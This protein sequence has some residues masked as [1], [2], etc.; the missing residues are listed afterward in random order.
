MMEL[1]DYQLKSPITLR[2]LW[3][4]G[5]RKVILVCPTGGGKTIIAAELIKKLKTAKKK[6]LFLVHRAELLNQSYKK[7]EAIGASITV[8]KSGDNRIKNEWDVMIATIQTLKNRIIPLVDCVI[9]DECH[10]SAAP[11]WQSLLNN[12]GCV[13]VGLTA[14]PVRLDGKSLADI[15][16]AQFVAITM[17][18]LLEKNYLCPLKWY[19]PIIPS[20]HIYPDVYDAWCK[21]AKNKKTI[22]FAKNV[23]HSLLIEKKFQGLV[24]HIDASTSPS[25]RAKIIE[26]FNQDKLLGLT[27]VNI[28]SEGLD[29]PQC[30]CIILA[31][32]TT[33]LTSFLQKIGRGMRPH[34]S[35]TECLILDLGGNLLVHGYPE[36]IKFEK[37][38]VPTNAKPYKNTQIKVIICSVCFIAIKSYP[39]ANCGN[40]PVERNGSITEQSVILEEAAL[41]Y[42]PGTLNYYHEIGKKNGYKKGW[43]YYKWRSGR[44][45]SSST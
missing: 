10:L 21:Y 16:D 37:S 25:E 8:C 45:A 35:K 11:S 33:S 19:V 12:F 44:N 39:C 6:C 43:A 28:V 17:R 9:V 14:T 22:I 41:L 42:P 1:R 3:V 40:K 15:Y 36:D 23:E 34:S 13:M 20:S 32:K 2:D 18:Q 38:F 26:E 4:R 5:S 31:G 7:F 30:A 29:V 24:K 27:N